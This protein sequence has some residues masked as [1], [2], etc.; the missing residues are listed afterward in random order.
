VEPTIDQILAQIKAAHPG[1]A[2]QLEHS[3]QILQ[4]AVQ[5]QAAAIAR[6]NREHHE[7]KSGD[8]HESDRIPGTD[9]K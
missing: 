2:A 5:D 7:H 1:Q 4:R 9:Q 3:L 6:G 8:L